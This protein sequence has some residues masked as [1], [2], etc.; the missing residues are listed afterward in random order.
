MWSKTPNN[1]PIGRSNPRRGNH[2]LSA[3]LWTIG[4]S[5]RPI[6]EFIKLLQAH[7]IERLV[8]VRTVPRSRH[9][10]QFNADTLAGSLAGV[11]ISYRHAAKLGGLRKPKKDSL[12]RGWRNE[13]FR[14]Y[15]DYM[16]TD[17]FWNA[18][19]ALMADSR[20]T[21]VS[22]SHPGRAETRPL[23][24]AIMCAEAVPWRCHRSLI[25]DA[26]VT[27][28][29]EV[30]HILS[31]TRADRH[32]LTPFATYPNGMLHYPASNAAPRLF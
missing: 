29:C 5:T 16:Q 28:G 11:G 31:E 18:L 26:L 32:Q 9:N 30:H 7:R 6:D 3:I 2:D 27:R 19:E 17:E 22:P 8:D 14:G 21:S 12:N 10:P 23:H 24:V 20:Q 25:A 4:H 13:S 15:A 1:W